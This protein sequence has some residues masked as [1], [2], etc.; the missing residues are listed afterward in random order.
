MLKYRY[1]KIFFIFC[2]LVLL[3]HLGAM[4]P[5]HASES[6]PAESP[7][8]TKAATLTTCGPY[9]VR[10]STPFYLGNRA[11][12]HEH[13]I[14]NTRIQF[15]DIA[16]IQ[17]PGIALLKAQFQR[18]STNYN[19]DARERMKSYMIAT[20]FSNPEKY[21]LTSL[22]VPKFSTV[23][24]ASP[25]HPKAEDVKI[26]NHREYLQ[27]L[28]KNGFRIYKAIMFS[29]PPHTFHPDDA[30]YMM[31]HMLKALGYLKQL[32]KKITFENKPLFRVAPAEMKDETFFTAVFEQE[33]VWGPT[34]YELYMAIFNNYIIDSDGFSISSE[35]YL[36]QFNMTQESAKKLLPR[37]D[38]LTQF[39]DQLNLLA[40]RIPFF[41]ELGGIT[42]TV[43]DGS[44]AQVYFDFNHGKNIVY[45]P[46]KDEFVII[47]G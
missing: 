25:A 18:F 45:D 40:P 8:Q 34:A 31:E 12:P 5:G 14:P 21:I 17:W 35:K 32:S 3:A 42:N 11:V 16:E 13:S 44:S 15:P 26:M 38:M 19:G 10:G 36:A 4:T 2:G 47:D 39:Y 24:L 41:E 23:C 28:R 20:G 46:S 30:I 1:L 9:F 33:Y 22:K 29:N 6:K 27:W 43:E 7:T 37:L